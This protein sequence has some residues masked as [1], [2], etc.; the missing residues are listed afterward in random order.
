MP[1]LLTE[2]DHEAF[3][4]CTEADAPNFW[5]LVE[6]PH[7]RHTV[8]LLVFATRDVPEWL[9]GPMLLAACQTTDPSFNRHFVAPCVLR[10]GRRR[11][12]SELM[13]IAQGGSNRIKVGAANA[14]Y[15][16]A[17]K[18]RESWW[19][20]GARLHRS[21]EARPDESIDDLLGSFETW[22]VNEFLTTQSVELQRSLVH[23][24]SSERVRMC[25]EAKIAI[26]QAR[27]HPDGY[28]RARL[29]VDLGESNLFPCRL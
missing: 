17:I 15:W 4:K 2:E 18:E 3:R 27:V 8:K 5:Q 19:P 12:V 28:I 10:F 20:P 21:L 7:H 14:M 26:E 25:P 16:G 6:H 23:Y 24:I 13:R 22:A 9:V 11:V 29:Q 1:G